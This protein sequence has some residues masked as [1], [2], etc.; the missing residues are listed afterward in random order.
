MQANEIQRLSVQIH[1]YFIIGT[2][3]MITGAPFTNMD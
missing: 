2:F 1:K 3:E